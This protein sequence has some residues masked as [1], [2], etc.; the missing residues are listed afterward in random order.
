MTMRNPALIGILLLPLAVL[1]PRTAPAQTAPQP[2]PP[3]EISADLGT[4]SALITVTDAD[5]RPIYAAKVA[6][7]IHYGMMG[8]KRL[9]LEAATSPNGQVKI[10]T[11]PELLKKPMFIII[12]NGDRQQTVEFKPELRCHATFDVQLR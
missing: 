8:V 9:D 5:S 11:L 7:R 4:C 6:T 3:T 12:S 10:T 2:I 1:S